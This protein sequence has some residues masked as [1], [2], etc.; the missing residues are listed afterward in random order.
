MLG[1][2][3]ALEVMAPCTVDEDTAYRLR[4]DGKK[5]GAVLPPHPFV[6]DQPQIGFVDQGRRLQAAAGP[7]AFQ[8][9]VRQAVELVVDDRGQLSERALV[10]VGPRTEQ[11]ADIVRNLSTRVLTPRGLETGRGIIRG[12]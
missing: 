9:V 5:M 6:V 11:S 8:V 1:I 12:R 3:A 2:R 10:P 7:L 4:G